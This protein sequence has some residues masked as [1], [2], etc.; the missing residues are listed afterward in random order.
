MNRQ[1]RYNELIKLTFHIVNK[2]QAI[3][4]ISQRFGTEEELYPR[5]IHTIQAIGNY[6]GT[7]ITDLA[8]RLGITKGTISPIVTKLAKKKFVL[9][10][11]G[12]ENNKEVILRLTPKGQVAYHAHEMFE[13]QIHSKLFDI[14]EKSSSENLEFLREF[15]LVCENI[16]DEHLK[17]IL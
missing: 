13:Q 15:L 4:K 12:I 2:F 3:E 9:K 11:K 7:N 17:E 5:E 6:P 10:L 8:S 16:L 1:N 14:L